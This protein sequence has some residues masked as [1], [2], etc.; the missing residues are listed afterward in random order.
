M[1][2]IEKGEINYLCFDS[3]SE[4]TMSIAQASL[5]TNPGLPGY[6][7]YLPARMEPIL[8]AAKE[9]GIKL[10]TNAGWLDP[11]GA[12]DCVRQ[13]AREQGIQDLKI[14]AVIGGVLTDA[15][16]DM[17]LSFVEDGA[18][19][20]ESRDSIVTGEVY[21]GASGIVDALDAGADVV[22]TTRVG[23]ACLYLGPL[24]YEFGWSLDDPALAAKG[25]IIGHLAEC[26]AQVSGGCFADPGYKE[27]PDLANVG[28]PI[29]EV[30]DDG[31]MTIS[32]IPGTGGLVSVA[33]CKEQL[34]Y[35]VQDPANYLCPDV[36]A[37]FSKVRFKQLDDDLVEVIAEDAG[38][39]RTSTLKA[40]VGLREGFA[41][42]EFVLFAGHGALKRAE[43]TKQLILDR[44][45]RAQFVADEIRW[46]Y[47]GLNSI[48]REATPEPKVEPYEVVL[49]V[50]IKT[51]TRQEAEKLG[52]EIDP[53]A[54]N[55]PSGIG[56][57]GTA[58]PGARIRPV[59]GLKAA[60]IPR[61]MVPYS[62][63]MR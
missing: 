21:Q 50:A 60:L 42:E 57:W 32:K 4:V 52:R 23:D 55:G 49:R 39:P 15:I 7:P 41:S 40:L 44:L 31:R 3:M 26:G 36:V 19:I 62:V 9:K 63:E 51:K 45:E 16:A 33:T 56:K 28:N 38:K 13:I 14:A 61:E 58:S 22:I 20:S 30:R 47:V 35:E 37:D 43:L 11:V 6:D 24:A 54:V 34:L 29:V 18:L 59:I 25:M 48:H 5:D 1:E 12:A 17:G 8:R 27:V 2:L 46:D 53:L 10:I